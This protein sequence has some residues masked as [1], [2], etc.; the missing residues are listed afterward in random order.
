MTFAKFG[1]LGWGLGWF[2][3]ILSA[4]GHLSRLKT[5]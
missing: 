1:L 4:M 3:R 2:R 5:G